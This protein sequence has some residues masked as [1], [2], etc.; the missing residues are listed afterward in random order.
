MGWKMKNRAQHP[1]GHGFEWRKAFQESRPLGDQLISE[2]GARGAGYA[3]QEQ[4]GL[5]ST[6]HRDLLREPS[7][8][9]LGQAVLKTSRQQGAAPHILPATGTCQMARQGDLATDTFP[10]TNLSGHGMQRKESQDGQG[11]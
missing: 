2:D 6:L 1:L 11:R 10:R 5:R 4:A 9:S 8:L 7:P 3:A